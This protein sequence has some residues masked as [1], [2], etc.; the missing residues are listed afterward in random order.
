VCGQPPTIKWYSC[1]SIWHLC[2][3]TLDGHA[4]SARKDSNYPGPSKG[5]LLLRY[6]NS[7]HVS[8]NLLKSA[9]SSFVR[10]FHAKFEVFTAVLL[11]IE[12][13]WNLKLCRCANSSLHLDGS[14]FLR[15]KIRQCK[16][17]SRS[18]DQPTQKET[19]KRNTLEDLIL[20]CII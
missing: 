20:F 9:E 13:F 5:S 16:K 11:Q 3:K 6:V 15:L 17:Y 8:P 19:T 7:C 12:M 2:L 10:D 4:R 18:K 1:S 14:Y